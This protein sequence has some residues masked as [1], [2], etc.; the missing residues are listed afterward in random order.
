[1]IS[2]EEIIVRSW[3][4]HWKSNMH[5]RLRRIAHPLARN[6]NGRKLTVN[7]P[8]S[9]SQLDANFKPIG[10]DATRRMFVW[11]WQANQTNNLPV[12]DLT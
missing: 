11:Q 7:T 10:N 9:G 6:Q 1:M 2:D 5:T 3:P 4:S 12:L 8:N